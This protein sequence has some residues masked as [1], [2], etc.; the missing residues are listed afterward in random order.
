MKASMSSF[1]W[2]LA[3]GFQPDPARECI[4]EFVIVREVDATEP[5]PVH[6]LDRR[7]RSAATQ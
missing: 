1:D 5:Q 3:C 7:I 4:V 2:F 6:V